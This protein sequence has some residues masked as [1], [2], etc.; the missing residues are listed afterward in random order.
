MEW[1]TAAGVVVSLVAAAFAGWQATEAR[2]ARISAAESQ[3]AAEDAAS[4]AADA[5]T[6]SAQSLN[7]IAEIA[8][9]QHA[10]A[11][12]AAAVKPDPW[13][14]DGGRYVRSGSTRMLV[15]GGSDEVED[16]ELTFERKPSMLHFD[17]DP[18]PSRWRPGDAVELYWM[19]FGAD[20]ST[21]VVEVHWRR[22]GETE[23]RV[24]RSTLS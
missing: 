12:A 20:S 23:R 19:M 17:P 3:D 18:V 7:T 4:R 6:Q 16:V 9:Q 5:Q 11:T 1:L 14:L 15:L 13:R 22:A 10:A 21:F 24:S 8:S 2:R